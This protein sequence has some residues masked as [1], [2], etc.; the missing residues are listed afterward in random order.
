MKIA[1][2]K[3]MM[4]TQCQNSLFEWRFSSFFFKHN[5]PSGAEWQMNFIKSTWAVALAHNVFLILP[6]C[7]KQSLTVSIKMK[8][9][10]LLLMYP[11]LCF[12]YCILCLAGQVM[13]MCP[14]MQLT[15]GTLCCSLV[16]PICLLD[17][18]FDCCGSWE[19]P[20]GFF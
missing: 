8:T 3:E 12:Y 15:A 2:F 19:Q 17:Q 9:M 10:F 14:V 11:M 1:P 7:R 13:L 18:L 5:S 4:V 20:V 16:L 6:H